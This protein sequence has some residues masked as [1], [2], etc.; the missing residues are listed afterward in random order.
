MLRTPAPFSSA[1]G[2]TNMRI[3][4]GLTL[5]VASYMSLA[6]PAIDPNIYKHVPRQAVIELA[7]SAEAHFGKTITSLAYIAHDFP[8]VG[9]QAVAVKFAPTELPDKT[10]QFSSGLF[11]FSSWKAEWGP[12]LKGPYT[13][14]GRWTTS[15]ELNNQINH[16]LLVRGEP[17]FVSIA[18]PLTADSVQLLL[19]AIESR[20]YSIGEVICPRPKIT[21]ILKK[22]GIP[23]GDELDATDLHTAYRD[24]YGKEDVIVLT[25]K[26]QYWWSFTQAAGSYHLVCV[27]EGVI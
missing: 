20:T 22:V 8:P 9:T 5:T 4:V 13:E 15:S 16:R 10:Y 12:R 11:Y 1:L 26:N 7:I 3:A 21:A 14:L 18:A 23:N 25:T 17:I 24:K 6:E 2:L 19:T 27:W